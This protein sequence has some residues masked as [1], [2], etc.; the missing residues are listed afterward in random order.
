MAT[1]IPE[2]G[3]SSMNPEKKNSYRVLVG[4][5][6]L[7]VV[8]VIVQSIVLARMNDRGAD[9]RGQAIAEAGDSGDKPT[10]KQRGDDPKTRPRPDP[11]D[12]WF[13]GVTGNDR[14]DPFQEMNRMQEHM[15]RM[16][17]DAFG[18]FGSSHRFGSLV[19][20]RSF[21]PEMDL[22]EEENRFVLRVDLPGVDK[23][24]VNVSVSDDRSV[25]I[26]GKREEQVED[27]DDQGHSIRTERR[28]GSFQRTLMLPEPVDSSAMTVEHEDGTLI[29]TLPKKQD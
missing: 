3:G 7:L 21:S 9:P 24:D 1:G 13:Q 16:F 22:V 15:N 23:A 27:K 19:Q 14:W 10:V 2:E 29:V 11:F 6:V 18:R 28:M 20:D 8:A 5:V 12:D 4:A 26:S 17:E 25:T